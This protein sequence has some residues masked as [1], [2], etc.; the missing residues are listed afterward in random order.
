MRINERVSDSGARR[1]LEDTVRELLSGLDVSFTLGS[2]SF[3]ALELEGL[4]EEAAANFL[5]RE[6][7]TVPG[8]I[9]EGQHLRGR[10]R[11]SGGRGGVE[12]DLGGRRASLSG[13]D[14]YGELGLVDGLPVEVEVITANGETAVALTGEEVERLRERKR[15][16][17]VVAVGCTRSRLK[18]AIR[19][20][21][22]DRD[23]EW[24][25]RLGL[26]E[27]V[28]VCRSGT[29]PPGL[30]SRL[31]SYLPGVKLHAVM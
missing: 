3:P 8:A 22:S 1:S 6:M 4:D 31:G 24:V 14:R 15:R 2:G 20:T 19:S 23:V 17:A 26:S 18:R 5:E 13:E 11:N 21:G 27:Q 7:D 28:A 12:M 16:G 25:E 10:I 9:E 29:S 30:I